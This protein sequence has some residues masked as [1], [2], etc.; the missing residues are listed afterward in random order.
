MDEHGNN[1]NNL[2]EDEIAI[3][4]APAWVMPEFVARPMDFDR[5]VEECATHHA[6]AF[7][8]KPLEWLAELKR[9][10]PHDFEQLRQRLKKIGIRLA[11]FDQ[12][13]AAS[14]TTRQRAKRAGTTQADKLIKLAETAQLFRTPDGVG[15]ADININGHRETWPVRSKTFRQ[16]LGREFFTTTE[17]APNS[18]AFAAALNV[19]EAR[20]SF[21][22]P[23]RRVHLRVAELNGKLYLDLCDEAWRAVEIDATGWRT[24]TDVPVRFRHA[25]GMLTIP[26]PVA[27]G[28]LAT[29]HGFLNLR[30]EADLDLVD[31]YLQASLR[32]G[33]NYPVLALGGEHGVAKTFT[34]KILR[35]LIDPNALPTR[36]PPRDLRD[37]FVQATNNQMLPFDNLST[38]QDWLSDALARLS[39]GAGWSTRELFANLDEVVFAGSRPI[40]LNSIADIVSRADLADRCASLTLER[41]DDSKRRAEEEMLAEFET[42][43]PRILGGLLDTVAHGLQRLPLTSLDQLPRM[44]DFALWATACERADGAFMRAYTSNR[45]D[46]VETVLE[47]DTVAQ[48]VREFLALR[49]PPQWDGTATALLNQLNIIASERTKKAK[50]WPASA[51]ALSGRLRRAAP[52]LRKVKI[53]VEFK[54]ENDA[55]RTRKIFLAKGPAKQETAK[56]SNVDRPARTNGSDG[57]DGEPLDAA[58]EPEKHCA[59]CGEGPEAGELQACSFGGDS[60]ILLHDHCI[61]AVI[62]AQRD[63]MPASQ[64]TGHNSGALELVK[65]PPPATRF[66]VPYRVVCG[67]CAKPDDDHNHLLKHRHGDERVWLHG[68]CVNAYAKKVAH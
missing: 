52:L 12:A 31:A 41:I 26:D 45:D 27:G 23:I 1:N 25:R 18:D 49:D 36:S 3:K 68:D 58:A 43:R 9:R 47:D 53:K 46:A 66:A 67:Q 17:G 33:L 39:S 65:P 14:N 15:Y 62:A 40:I 56:Q 22:A 54:R 60:I 16:W 7:D 35:A 21:E 34:C 55:D 59:C 28:S 2:R 10:Q 42:A 8:R 38:L 57:S 19:I 50:D 51:N 24:I 32:D 5:L 48:A 13:V 20:A 6:Q 29:L 30:H 63:E 44:A 61:D 64:A 11:A 37:L 4:P